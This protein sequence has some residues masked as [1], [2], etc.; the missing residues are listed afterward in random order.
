MGKRLLAGQRG[1]LDKKYPHRFLELRYED[2]VGDPAAAGQRVFEFLGEPWEPSVLDFDAAD[3]TATERY[4]WFTAQRREA[5]GDTATIYGSR[6][7]AG[8]RSLDP[9][10]RTLL[11]RGSGDLLRE[12]GYLG[13]DRVR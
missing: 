12:L 13:P 11:R 6:V 7:G 3:H 8:G 4:Q 9:V 2:L 10:L 5:A 1:I